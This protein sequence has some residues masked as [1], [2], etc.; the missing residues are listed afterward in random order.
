MHMLDHRAPTNGEIKPVSTHQS[1][2]SDYIYRGCDLHPVTM[3]TSPAASMQSGCFCG[4]LIFKGRG[5]GAGTVKARAPSLR[6][7]EWQNSFR[8][9]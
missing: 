4:W 8:S 9:I 3:E 2:C 1:Q 7:A 5:Y 6:A